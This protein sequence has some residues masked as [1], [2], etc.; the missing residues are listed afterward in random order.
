MAQGGVLDELYPPGSTGVVNGVGMIT[1][2]DGKKYI[3]QTPGDNNN[4]PLTKGVAITFT[5]TNGRHI[6]SVSQKP[7]IMPT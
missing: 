2:N 6:E 3:F 5:V 1:G 7:I 4:Q